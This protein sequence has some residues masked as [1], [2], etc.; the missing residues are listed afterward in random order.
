MR[1]HEGKL[2]AAILS[3]LAVVLIVFP[4]AS[5]AMDGDL[6]YF[7]LANGL[8]VF[9]KEDHA[10]KVAAIQM[11]VQVG[12]AYENDSERGISHVIEHMAFKGTKK[13]GAGEIAKEVEAIGGEINAYTSWDETVFHIVVPSSAAPR[14]LDIVTDAVLRAVIDAKELDR[15]KKVVLEEI[16][17]EKD[18]PEEVASNLL[19]ETAYVKSP[20]RFPVIGKKEIVEKITRKNILD[21]R[22]KWYVPENMFLLVVGDVDPVSVRADV[23]RLT[24]DVNP[25]PFFRPPLP[26]EPP[27][28][29]IRGA[30]LRDPNATETRL[31]LAFHI[32]SMK[33][34]DVNALDLAADI[35][36][37]REDSRLV[38]ELKQEKAI[39][40]SIS[41]YSLTPKESGL[42]TFSATIEAA[43]LE[44]ATRGI[45]EALAR[46]SQE[47][48]PAEELEQAKTHIESQHV[49][50]RETVQGTAKSIGTYQNDLG[51]ASYTEKYLALN[52][53][54]TPRQVSAAVRKYLVPPNV[55]VSVLLPD[56]EAKD[57]GIQQLE[58]IVGSFGPVAKTSAGA[59][60]PPPP[61]VLKELPN[62]IRVVLA[63]DSSN[64]VISFRIAC[65]GGKRFENKDTQGMMN[66]I[67]RMLDKGTS[68]MTQ[69]DI[70]RKVDHMGGSLQGFSGNDSFGLYAS[71]FSRYGDQALELLY[72]LYTAAAFPQDKVDR[73]RDLIVN[74][75][76][77]EPDNPTEYVI[78]QL[79]KT[80]F[81]EFPYGFD[82]LGTPATVVGFTADEL[83]Q[84][85]QRYAVPS[86]TVIA[87]VGQMDTERMWNRIVQLFG[88]MP[89]KPLE[90]PQIVPEKPLEKVRETVM[91][92]P[93]AIAHLAIGFR[94]TTFADPDRFALD[95]LNNVLTGQGGRLFRELRDKESLAYV[96]TSFVRPGLSPGL[97]GLYLACDQPKVDRAYEGLVKQIDLIRA[98]KVSDE[99]LERAANNLIGNHLIS[100]QSSS[101]RAE[102]LGLY[103]LYGLG[104]D[105]DPEYIARIRE[106]KAEDVLRVAQKYVDLDHCAVVKILPE[107]E[108]KGD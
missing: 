17:E 31:D 48:P 88:K 57:F 16:L 21:F 72:Q 60:L 53:A 78:N 105:F 79:N 51:D 49:Y 41:A 70:A 43:N 106:V 15:E 95:V 93:R 24:S 90:M 23:E 2:V 92:V 19:F 18:R 65:L 76:K 8:D 96:V 37:A 56:G 63:P 7:R 36:G 1:T 13:R 102:L 62:G 3:A 81:P 97:F 25:T 108:D 39:V 50:A 85:Y 98:A 87:V 46:L 77:T 11:W 28:T 74:N 104:Y 4:A 54:V 29:Q 22:S 107:G 66:F 44:A 32:P 33:G 69:Q 30:V 103:T 10:R 68:R 61:T 82:K 26:Q 6:T 14:G 75:I 73:E 5:C 64:P 83:K 12:S 47:P 35:L 80:V 94:G 101:D 45:M 20:Y 58:E 59:A 99:E 27:Q 9:V 38:R 67:S 34:N 52:A 42:M 86:N 100:L 89:A 84:T 71:F 55:T 40:H 91:H